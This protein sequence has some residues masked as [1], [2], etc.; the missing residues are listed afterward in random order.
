MKC[1][2]VTKVPDG[3]SGMFIERK[4]NGAPKAQY[5]VF[6]KGYYYKWGNAYKTV[7]HRGKKLGTF[8]RVKDRLRKLLQE[9]EVKKNG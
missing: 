2:D 1:N 8:N 3:F 9:G 6:G 4:P 5:W 7:F